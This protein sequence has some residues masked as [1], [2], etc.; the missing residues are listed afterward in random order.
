[1]RTLKLYFVLLALPCAALAG[2]WW[3]TRKP[4]LKSVSESVGEEYVGDN[5]P[6]V[7]PYARWEPW[8]R[9]AWRYGRT[10]GD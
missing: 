5:N 9:G 7:G 3:T 10:Y 6:F 4:S 1:M 8:Q 2:L